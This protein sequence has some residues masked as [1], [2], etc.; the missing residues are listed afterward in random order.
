MQLIYLHCLG[1]MLVSFFFSWLRC[2]WPQKET[3]TKCFR[4]S[5]NMPRRWG[6]GQWMGD[7]AFGRKLGPLTFLPESWFTV[8]NHPFLVKGN[9]YWRYTHF[10][11]NHEYGRKGENVEIGSFCFFKS[12]VAYSCFAF[13]MCLLPACLV[14][15]SLSVCW[16]LEV[17]EEFLH[18]CFVF[19]HFFFQ[20]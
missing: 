5:G 14:F 2:N 17:S 15:C 18:S 20:V 3:S 11:L 12:Q 1:S 4:S 16:F 13:V 6:A 8:E 19:A 7:G 9:K 10:P